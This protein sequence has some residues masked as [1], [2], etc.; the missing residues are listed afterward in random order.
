LSSAYLPKR[1]S[2]GYSLSRKEMIK[3]KS[4]TEDIRKAE[5]TQY[6]NVNTIQFF[7]PYELLK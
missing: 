7:S 6:T 5:K 4:G 3:K 2:K 1:I